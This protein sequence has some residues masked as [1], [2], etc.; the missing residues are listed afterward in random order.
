MKKNEFLMVLITSLW[1][2]ANTLSAVFVNVYLYTYTGSLVV[3]T[4]YC[5]IRIAQFPMFFTIGGK[6]A[7]RNGY[8]YPLSTGVIV[9]M[10]SLMYVLFMNDRFAENSNLVYIS[11]L[12]VGI[13]EGF[14]WLSVNSLHQVV[15]TPDTRSRYLAN[16]GIFNNISNIIAPIIS[17]FIINNSVSDNAGYI[18]IFK[19]VLVIYVIIVAAAFQV[20]VKGITKKFSVIRCMGIISDARWRRIM[21]MTFLY[22]MRDA[23]VLTLAGLLVYNATDGSG[24]LYS[25]LLTVFALI[26]IASYYFF[27]KRLKGRKMYG[28]FYIGALLMALSTIVLVMIPNI[29]GAIFYGIVNGIASPMYANP[30]QIIAMDVINEYNRENMT[31]RVIAK[32]IYLSIG[33]C[34]GMLCIVASS[35]ILNPDIF[36]KVSVVFCSMFAIWTAFYVHFTNDEVGH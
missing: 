34:T 13:G 15:S 8:A 27:S 3:M 31:G 23:L 35:F 6:W 33:R 24:G 10:M 19:F 1:A 32:E 11:A 30:Y 14:F 7:Q 21:I 20:N 16:I 17:T 22:G 12:L 4:I 18:T 25:K 36:L 26:T 9:S 29:Y 5:M 2:L 28:Y